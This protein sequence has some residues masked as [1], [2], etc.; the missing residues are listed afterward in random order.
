[1]KKIAIL[2]LLASN[3]FLVVADPQINACIAGV[4]ARNKQL[5]G[6]VTLLVTGNEPT[7]DGGKAC[8]RMGVVGE[9]DNVDSAMLRQ[10]ACIFGYNTIIPMMFNSNVVRGNGCDINGI[11]ECSYPWWNYNPADCAGKGGGAPCCVCEYPGT[12]NPATNQ[13]DGYGV[14]QYG[15]AIGWNLSI[16]G[17][18]KSS[19]GNFYYN[20][21]MNDVPIIGNLWGV[22][23]GGVNLWGVNLD[24]NSRGR[25]ANWLNYYANWL[26]YIK[27]YIIT[28][29]S[30]GKNGIFP[31][32]PNN[33]TIS[34]ANAVKQAS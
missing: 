14:C 18:Q 1:M 13:P 26:N 28:L 21:K 20:Q 10:A 16:S 7:I 33:I 17:T 2:L 30:N 15:K 23:L 24:Q 8:S 3:S 11:A 34:G 5:G 22:D 19:P 4:N 31:E 9:N 6:G 25:Y 29:K 12:M 27:N 32:W